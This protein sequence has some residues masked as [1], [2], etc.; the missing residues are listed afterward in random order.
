MKFCF[1]FLTLVMAFAT[2]AEDINFSEFDTPRKELDVE[3]LRWKIEIQ[4]NL[5]VFNKT[6]TRLLFK[7][8]EERKWRFGN[9]KPI[10]SYWNVATKGLPTTA[11][12]HEWQ[13][14]AQGELQ[15]KFRQYDSMAKNRD[16]SVKTGKLLQE[17]DY[18]VENMAGPSIVLYQDDTRRIVAQFHIQ[19]WT[20]DNTV[21]IG[22]LG[23]NSNRM[24]IFDNKGN[25]WASRLDNSTGN[26]VYYGVTTH[27]GSVYMSYLP[28]EGAKKIGVAEKNRIRIDQGPLRILI[29][30]S[31]ALLPRGIQAN[32]YG[33]VDLN[34]R[35]ERLNQVRS[36][37]SDKE[38]NFLEAIK[39]K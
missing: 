39:Q 23:I 34:K 17:K 16:G 35:T 37:G 12:Y 11:L 28:F 36:N 18:T 33:I 21:D 15:V 20:D 24:T 27:Q 14:N 5:L 10:T 25:V 32:V 1:L 26:N 22:K 6:G 4:G 8:D 30:S 9:D 29:E 38:S 19:V 13:F 3:S 2:H 31:D 7:A